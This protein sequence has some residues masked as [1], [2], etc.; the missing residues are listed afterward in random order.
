MF[1][2]VVQFGDEIIVVE[3]FLY[4]LITKVFDLLT[5]KYR[6]KLKTIVSNDSTVDHLAVFFG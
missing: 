6:W 4:R 3:F 5:F 2:R 1:C